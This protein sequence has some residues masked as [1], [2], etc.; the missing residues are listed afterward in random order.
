MTQQEDDDDEE[1]EDLRP[2]LLT[3]VMTSGSNHTTPAPFQR[4]T[5]LFTHIPQ[6]CKFH[7]VDDFYN[8]DQEEEGVI[9]EHHDDDDDDDDDDDIVV[10]CDRH[11][12]LAGKFQFWALIQLSAISTNLAV[13][14]YVL[15][16]SFLAMS[17]LFCAIYCATMAYPAALKEHQQHVAVT[18][19][20]IRIDYDDDGGIAASSSKMMMMM[21]IPFLFE[22]IL[23]PFENIQSCTATASTKFM[24]GFFSVQDLS[25]VQLVVICS[26][27]GI[28]KNLVLYGIKQAPQ[29]FVE[30]IHAMMMQQDAQ[31]RRGGGGGGGTNQEVGGADGGGGED[32][33][34][35]HQQYST[36]Q[37][38]KKQ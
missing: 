18:T 5:T 16:G 6:A 28:R 4:T 11:A 8:N 31:E 12:E 33:Q 10:V 15:L 19:K 14:C 32:V 2:S 20:G 24:Y 27:S 22:S 37:P 3:N 26:I 1:E 29:D 30:L 35:D 25:C 36:K 23:V 21:I 38:R 9:G 7:W 34:I 17:F 13:L